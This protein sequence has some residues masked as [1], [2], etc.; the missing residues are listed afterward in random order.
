[1]HRQSIRTFNRPY[2]LDALRRGEWRFVFPLWLLVL[3]LFLLFVSFRPLGLRSASKERSRFDSLNLKDFYLD[4]LEKGVP[5]VMSSF[6]EATGR[7][8][9][10]GWCVDNQEVIYPLAYLYTFN[11]H[12]NPH[13]KDPKLLNAALKGGD[14]ICDSQY[15]D[16]TVELL[17]NNGSSWGRTYLHETLNAW[18]ETYELLKD[19]MEASQRRRWEQGITRQIEGIQQ[20]IQG[21]HNLRLH[22][23][24]FPDEDV[25]WDVGNFEVNSYSTWNG[26]NLYRAGQIFGRESWQQT[27]QKMVYAALEWLDPLGFWPEYG[28]PSPRQNLQT[29]QALGLY[30]EYSGDLGAVPYLEKGQDFLMKFYYPDGSLVETLDGCF[31]YTPGVPVFAQ[32]AFSQFPTGRRFTRYLSSLVQTSGSVWPLSAALTRNLRYFHEGKEEKIFPDKKS[33]VITLGSQA[34]VRRKPPWF[35]GLSGFTA[36][37]VKSRWA[38]DRQNFVSVWHDQLGLLITGGSSK[39]QSDWSNFV[40]SRGGRPIYIP[41]AAE[42]KEKGSQDM[43]SL[44]YDDKRV[45]LLVEAASKQELRIKAQLERADQEVIGHFILNLR[46]GSALKSASGTAYSLTDRPIEITSEGAGGW[47]ESGGWR[48]TLPPESKVT[49]PSLPYCPDDRQLRTP[50]SESHANLTYT[51]NSASPSVSF[52]LRVLRP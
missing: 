26:V 34:L 22:S 36:V 32:F 3:L 40:F 13:F 35:Y 4:Q 39:R 24:I 25:P 12:A 33:Y 5:G 49:Y 30:Y 20:L 19:Q 11:H 14:A 23:G 17:R 29:L 15:E 28:G 45:T 1:M 52:T 43:V 8:S 38:L 16:G 2:V 21:V 41:T 47:I 10:D 48:L 18:L 44:T 9:R 7:F 46:P 31:R 6:I 42:V 37:P 50:A 51:L 27:G